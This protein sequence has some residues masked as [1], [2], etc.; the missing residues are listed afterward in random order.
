ME[1]HRCAWTSDGTIKPD[2]V[3]TRGGIKLQHNVDLEFAQ[4]KLEPLAALS[5]QEVRI[6][7]KHLG[8]PHLRQPFPGPGLLVRTVGIYSP[9]KLAVEKKANDIVEQEYR[10]HMLSQYGREMIIDGE[11]GMQIPFQT[12]AATFDLKGHSAL[13]K[14]TGL[15]DDGKKYERIYKEPLIISD[16]SYLKHAEEA[17]E[18]AKKNN[19]HRILCRLDGKDSGKFAV[20]IR[21]IDSIDVKTCVPNLSANVP[22]KAAGRILKELPEVSAVFF[23]ITPKPPG[24]VEYE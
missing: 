10:K 18:I 15:V 11:T 14:V 17:L 12:F 3:E 21:A 7:A 20:A 6:L 2:I 13:A 23:D 9:E 16:G 8:I 1:S 24:T 4:K 22:E 5:K 19:S